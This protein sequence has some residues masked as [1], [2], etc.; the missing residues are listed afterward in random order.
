M[1]KAHASVTQLAEKY[2]L[3]QKNKAVH[4][5]HHFAGRV[6]DQTRKKY[7]L[8]NARLKTLIASFDRYAIRDLEYLTQIARVM[9]FNTN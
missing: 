3:V 2:H 4:C 9:V 5:E 1:V 8:Q 7:M 6:R